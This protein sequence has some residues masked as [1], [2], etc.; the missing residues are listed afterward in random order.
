MIICFSENFFRKFQVQI[1]LKILFSLHEVSTFGNSVQAWTFCKNVYDWKI[2]MHTESRSVKNKIRFFHSELQGELISLLK[3]DFT[4]KE[5][6]LCSSIRHK[7]VN[8]HPH[9]AWEVLVTS[10]H[11]RTQVSLLLTNVYNCTLPNPYLVPHNVESS[12]HSNYCHKITL[13]KWV[14]KKQSL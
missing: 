2:Y 6:R 4:K 14:F 13:H 8:P 11:R 3:L 5:K 7:T 10:Y 9:R 1:V 12:V